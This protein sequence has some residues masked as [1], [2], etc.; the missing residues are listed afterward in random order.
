MNKR[1]KYEILLIILIIIVIFN[2]TI[3]T[4]N[5]LN[6]PT[7]E[8]NTTT[9]GTNANGT[10][11]KIEAGNQESNE[12]VGLILGVHSRENEIHEAV[13]QT[14]HNIT[15]ENGTNN[16]TKKYVIYYIDANDNLSSREETRSAGEQLASEFIV[17]NIKNDHPFVVIDIHEIDANYEYSSF[18]YSISND[19]TSNNYV[20]NISESIGVANFN[21]SEGTS[22]E[23]VT[24]PIAN[25]GIHTLLFETSIEDSIEEKRNTAYNLIYAIDQL[26]P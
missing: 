16:L 15:S 1:M 25:Q 24:G 8:Y 18:I 17:P 20:R 26:N 3:I 12:T 13:N 23:V 19:T 5:L 11:Y 10:V 9:V 2:I 7:N 6:Q 21:F 22:P 4:S 14:V